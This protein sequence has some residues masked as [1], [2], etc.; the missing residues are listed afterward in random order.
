MRYRVF[1]LV[2]VAWGLIGGLAHADGLVFQLPPDGTWARY[3]VK[4]DQE[5]GY[6][7]GPKQKVEIT[8]TLTISSVGELTRHEQKCR[9]IELKAESKTKGVYP[10]LVLKMLIPEDRL[11]RGQ[12]PLAHARLTFFSPKAVDKEK[13]ESFI[14]KG[15]NRIQYELDRF[16]DV[17]PKP[18][19][20]PKSLTRETVETQAGKFEDCEV[21]TGRSDYDGPVLGDGRSVFKASY[22]IVVHPQAPFGVVS[23]QIEIE[24]REISGEG[25]VSIKAKKTLTL[26]ETGKNA[27]SD[28]PKGSVER[29]KK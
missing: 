6:G 3:A 16:R 10:K 4:T 13:V 5:F 17:F 26:V 24:G 15:F 12:D 28:L 11:Q 21:L 9:W 23:M 25:A 20:N 27:V 7:D 18:L 1:P 22:R 8:G 19:N 14:D 2:A 29:P